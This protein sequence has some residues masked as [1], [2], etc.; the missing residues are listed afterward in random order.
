MKKTLIINIGNSIIHIEEDAYEILT[1]YL[2][3]IKQ[4]FAKDA[5]DF[6]IVTDIENRIAEMFSEIL[7]A[8]QKQVIEL[9]DVQSVIAQM[10]RV[11]DFQTEDEEEAPKAN[12]YTNH[13]GNKK[14]YRDTDEGVIAGVCVGVGHYLNIEA[15]WVRLIAFLSIFLGGSGILAYFILWFAMPRAVSRSEKMAMKGEATNLYGY[16][17]SFDEE[18]AAF[19]ENMKSANAHL[20]PMVKRSGNFITELI[21]VLGKF[22]SGTGK[23]IMRIIAGSFIVCG[24][25]MMICLI[26]C[27]AAFLGFWDSNAYDYFP[28]SII[29]QGFRSEIVLGAFVTLFIPVLALV[30]FAV[31]VAFNRMAI[32][33]T[34]SFA[35]LII[36]LIGVSSTVYYAA[37]ISSE[38]QE[39]AELVQTIE[40]KTY[41][42]YVID[43]DKSMA[44]SKDDSLAYRINEMDFGRRIIVDDS[45]DHPF[46]VPRNVRIEII[47]SENSKTT[48][49]QTYESQGKTFQVALQNA[50]NINYKYTQTDSLL[51]LSPRLDLKKESIW[52]NQEVHITLKVPVGTHLFLNDNIYNYLQFYYYSCN[53]DNEKDSEY[54][55][56][57]MTEEGLKCKSELDKPQEETQP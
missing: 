55:E 25:G 16:Q 37:K 28:L 29:N 26:I 14:L 54:R 40:L 45:D 35:L 19:K 4:H 17:R 44:L 38:F 7:Q 51:T 43:V 15:R 5:D 48:M 30:L 41:P 1:T 57:V 9:A 3:E 20:G 50:Q 24:F 47:K 10:G 6:E 2:I 21:D 13:I 36:W 32:N 34:V 23:V 33:K 46:R 56:W 22:L 11:Q 18:L 8:A 39:H 12:P 42:T 53:T 31:R 49:V 52:R 27:L